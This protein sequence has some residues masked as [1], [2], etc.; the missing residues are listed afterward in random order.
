MEALGQQLDSKEGN[1]F[2]DSSKVSSKAVLLHI[3][4][5]YPSVPTAHAF[6]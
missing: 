3:G 5:K 2:I 6:I 1:I 4:Y